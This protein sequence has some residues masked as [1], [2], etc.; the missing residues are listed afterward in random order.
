MARREPRSHVVVENCPIQWLRFECGMPMDRAPKGD[1]LAPNRWSA[2]CPG[3]KAVTDKEPRP[4]YGAPASMKPY[5]DW[6]NGPDSGISSRTLL[7]AITGRSFLPYRFG[8]DVP[9]DPADF[10]RCVRLLDNFP[11]LRPQ[12][13][14][15]AEEHPRWAGHVARWAEFEAMYRAAIESKAGT[16]P[17]LYAALQE[18]DRV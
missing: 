11:E 7:S 15:V 9:H 2:T 3:C 12:L 6:A 4:T 16:V 14:K 8:P 5:V 17:D 1:M 18:L 10:G 13:A